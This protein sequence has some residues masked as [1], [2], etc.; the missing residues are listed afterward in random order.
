LQNIECRKSKT[1]SYKTSSSVTVDI[2]AANYSQ[3]RY[4]NTPQTR[5]L[6]TPQTR[7]LNTPTTKYIWNFFIGGLIRNYAVSHSWWLVRKSVLTSW[8]YITRDLIETSWLGIPEDRINWWDWSKT[9]I[10][11]SQFFKRQARLCSNY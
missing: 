4:L 3:T 11:P 6:N 9:I 7:Y 8:L 1:L 10:I 2:G 5:Y